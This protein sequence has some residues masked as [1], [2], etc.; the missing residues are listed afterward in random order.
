MRLLKSRDGDVGVDLGGRKIGVTEQL[1]HHAQIGSLVEHVGGEGVAKFVRRHIERQ[2]S[3]GE[4]RFEQFLNLARLHAF[5]P[6]GANDGRV[7][8]GF[9]LEALHEGFEALHRDGA[10]RAEAFFAAFTKDAGDALAE[11]NLTVIEC[12]QF[13]H[14]QAPAVEQF[15]NKAITEGVELAQL[16]VLPEQDWRVEQ[17]AHLIFSEKL[18]QRLIHPGQSEPSEGVVC[19]D[20]L[21]AQIEIERA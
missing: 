10:E 9:Q 21:P 14:A 2:S 13:A 7:E 12:T 3:G 16:A 20:A 18:W 17:G 5:A 4:V 19:H 1:L 15:Q 8:R 11:I 6:A